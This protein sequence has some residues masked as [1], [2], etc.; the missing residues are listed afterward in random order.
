MAG[1]NA[2]L[3]NINGCLSILC[4]LPFPIVA[5]TNLHACNV[6]SLFEASLFILVIGVL[7]ALWAAY[8]GSRRWAFAALLPVASLFVGCVILFK[9]GNMFPCW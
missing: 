6:D 8:E 2:L 7:L 5:A 9:Y 4:N 3:A 1:K